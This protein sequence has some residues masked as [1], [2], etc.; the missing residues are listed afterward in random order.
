MFTAILRVYTFQLCR[1][2]YKIYLQRGLPLVWGQ[3]LH[4]NGGRWGV[5]RMGGRLAL[6]QCTRAYVAAGVWDYGKHT[7]PQ[8]QTTGEQ[9]SRSGHP[10][11]SHSHWCDL[12]QVIHLP[13]PQFPHV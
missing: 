9:G 12:G 5:R 3:C 8:K 1:Q 7:C 4:I 2:S 10:G 11:L 6:N 13:K